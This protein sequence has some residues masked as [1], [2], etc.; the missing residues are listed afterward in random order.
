VTLYDD[1]RT[2]PAS[3]LGRVR[4]HIGLEPT[5]AGEAVL[6]LRVKDKTSPHVPL[7]ARRLLAPFK[8]LVQPARNTAWF[9]AT[10]ALVARPVRYPELTDTIRARLRDY[11]RED[12]RALSDLLGRDLGFWLAQET[13]P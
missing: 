5:G 3:V 11:Y 9:R 13:G 8:G 4:A 2:Q 10:R 6:A 7:L 12:V 1:L